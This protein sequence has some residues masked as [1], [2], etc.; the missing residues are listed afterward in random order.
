MKVIQ[1]PHAFSISEI[2]KNLKTNCNGLSLKEVFKR[3]KIF[4]KNSVEEEKINYFKIFFRQF[5]NILVYVLIIASLISIFAGKWVDFFAIFFMILLN[6]IIGFFQEIKA[7]ASIKSL[8]KLTQDQDTVVRDGKKEKISSKELVPGDIVTLFEGSTVTCDM[9]LIES[10]NLAADESL[11]TGESLPIEKDHNLVLKEK[12]HIYE[13]KNMVFAGTS[14][15]RGSA[16]AVVVKT[17]GNTYFSS[18]TKKAEEKSP[19]TPLTKAIKFFAK[20]Y[21]LFL[22]TLFLIVGLWGYFQKRA[23]IDV[24]YILIAEL[25][26]AVPEGLP[27]VIT[28][29]MV[30]GAIALSKKKALVRY[31]PSVETLGSATYIASDKT[32]TITEGK[33]RIKEIY[34]INKKNLRMVASLCSDFVDGKKDPVDLE[35]YKWAKAEEMLKKYPRIWSL[36][37]DPELRLMATAHMVANEKK[38]FVKGAYETIK[39]YAKVS[40]EIDEKVEKMSSSGLRVIAFAMGDFKGTKISSWKLELAG[41]IGFY[42]PPKKEV[43]KAVQS[44]KNANIKVLMITGDHPLTAKSIAKEV[45]IYKEGDLIITSEDMEKIKEKDLYKI[46]KKTTVLARVLPEHKYQV[47]KILQKNKEIVVVSGDGVNDVPALKAADLGIA[48]GSGTEAAK[49]VSKM[50]ITNNNL[51]VIVD[52]IRNG[53]VI[54]DNI[55][56]VIYYLLS[57]SLQEIFLISFAIIA[58]LPLPLIPIQILWI[59]LVTDGVQDKAFPFAKEESDVMKREPKRPRTQFFDKVQVYR[60]LSF[61]LIMGIISLE[62]FKY[63]LKTYSYDV[64]VTILFS[65]VVMM[66]WFNGIQSQKEKE[67][68]FKNIKRSFKI[69]PYI[70]GSIAIGII[71]QLIAVY[72][73]SSWF[74]TVEIPISYWKYPIMISLIAFFVVEARKWIEIFFTFFRRKV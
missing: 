72:G 44:A 40:K 10:N 24:A 54:A 3:Q 56:K 69:N 59:N 19:K 33:I 13:Q 41:L 25:V 74:H 18:I 55:R 66:Q 47:V 4:G 7:E 50:I 61:G 27:I 65:T 36:G 31:L 2:L 58:G 73:L 49:S 42:D 6:S 1:N 63:L 26:S 39:K 71:L 35:L 20:N 22:I 48:M 46:L 68:F 32:G 21:I 34:A 60:I 23:I 67:P 11:L 16:K 53:R 43:A 45:G 30:L 37:F 70:F 28:L 62:L 17:A 38:L 51:K 8:K 52:M 9:R 12:T 15:F 64:A 14:I 5:A 57:S 29:V